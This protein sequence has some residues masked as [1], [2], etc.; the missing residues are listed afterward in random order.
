MFFFQFTWESLLFAWVAI[1]GN[2]LCRKR[3]GR[4]LS[5]EF[6]VDQ[7]DEANVRRDMN[8]IRNKSF[9]KTGHSFVPPSLFDAVPSAFVRMVLVLETRTND[10][11]RISGGGSDQLR[12][13]S[14]CQVLCGRLKVR[15]KIILAKVFVNCPRDIFAVKAKR[16]VIVVSV[17]SGSSAQNMWTNI[18]FS[19]QIN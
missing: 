7:H 6:F 5:C 2:F 11:V 10:L 19:V 17:F 13:C 16:D 8:E 1:I 3:K 9:V 18:N 15:K 4:C 12:Y 14:E